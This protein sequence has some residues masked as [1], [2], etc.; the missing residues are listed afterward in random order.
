M[1]KIVALTIILVTLGMFS[2]R[3]N[4]A[5][6]INVTQNGLDVQ[7]VGMGSLNLDSV[8]N[9]VDSA[10]AATHNF[11]ALNNGV[12]DFFVGVFPMAGD[13]YEIANV[14]I[15]GAIPTSNPLKVNIGGDLA[16]GVFVNGKDGGKLIVPSGYVSNASL[17][18]TAF[19]KDYNLTDYGFTHGDSI[20]VSWSNGAASD[21]LTMN[22]IVIPEPATGSLALGGA[23]LLGAVSR[24]RKQSVRR[25]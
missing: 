17:D 19:I 14:N 25:A 11:N 9:I 5:A 3:V 12:S 10:G 20:F 7:I 6:I 13:L 16:Q 2:T 23:M 15:S 18:F 8:I 1:K 4:A 21:S 22:F 24:R